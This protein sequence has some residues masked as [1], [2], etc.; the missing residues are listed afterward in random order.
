MLKWA[1]QHS[2]AWSAETCMEAARQG[3][4]VVLQWAHKHNCPWHEE[5]TRVALQ[6]RH[7]SLYLLGT[8]EWLSSLG[9]NGELCPSYCEG[10][11]KF[12]PG[13]ALSSSFT[14]PP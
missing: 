13:L 11:D 3:H 14:S 8:Q 10:C 4:L 6:E 5:T 12:V 7:L 2:C 9:H 1:R